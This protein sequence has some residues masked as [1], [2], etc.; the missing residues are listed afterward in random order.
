MK[1]SSEDSEDSTF[2]M[3]QETDSYLFNTKEVIFKWKV[4]G[5]RKK[6]KNFEGGFRK[7]EVSGLS[8]S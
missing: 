4:A 5:E 2:W 6:S 7:T 1:F 8:Q 3:S